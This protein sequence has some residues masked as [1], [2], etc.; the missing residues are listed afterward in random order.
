MY[1]IK[2]YANGRFYDTVTKNYI[3]RPQISKLLKS[4]K[5]I[6][7]I[8]TKTGKDITEEVVSQIHAKDQKAAKQKQLIVIHIITNR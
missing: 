7:V 3:T 6:E 1:T 2:K 5:K 8:F 4:K